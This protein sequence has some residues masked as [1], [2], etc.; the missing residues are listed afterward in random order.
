MDISQIF[1]ALLGGIVIF[2]I[3]SFVYVLDRTYMEWYK[4]KIF[5]KRLTIAKIIGNPTQPK[6]K[7]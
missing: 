1:S 2:L 7:K 6:E 3:A 5:L 4:R